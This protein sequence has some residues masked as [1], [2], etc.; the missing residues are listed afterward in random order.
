MSRGDRQR[1]ALQVEFGEMPDVILRRRSSVCT[2]FLWDPEQER[3]RTKGNI[4]AVEHTP[5][6]RLPGPWH[7][8]SHVRADGTPHGF[9]VAVAEPRA[10]E[11]L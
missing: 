3:H 5:S 1:G 6:P 8:E 2:G 9:L 10:G 11:I 4:E 7:G